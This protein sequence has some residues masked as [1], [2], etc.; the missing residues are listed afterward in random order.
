MLLLRT[1]KGE[2]LA[3]LDRERT[4]IGRD[5]ANDVVLE[6]ASVSGFHALVLNDR[7][8]VSVVDLGSTNGTAVDGKRLRERTELKAW[9]RLQLGGVKLVVADTEVR[10]PTRVQ[11]VVPAAGRESPGATSAK[12]T[13]VRPAAG[14]ATRVVSPV[15]PAG[16]IHFTSPR[17]EPAATR[18][19]VSRPPG[20][21]PAVVEDS[22]RQAETDTSYALF[23]GYPRGL[24]WLLFS[25]QGRIRRSLVWKVLGIGLLVTGIAQLATVFALSRAGFDPFSYAISSSFYGLLTIWPWTAIFAKRIHDSGRRAL[26]WCTLLVLGYVLGI[27]GNWLMANRITQDELVIFGG[28]SL[29]V[30]VPAIYALYLIWF[31]RGD[32]G[33][34]EFGDQNPRRR[35][36]FHA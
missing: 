15:Q 5:P 14:E 34:N 31:K 26:P 22:D 32:E 33:D 21:S 30:V 19:S 4:A 25:F 36:V 35:I 8:A 1:E 24:T 18:V 6:D 13:R 20:A 3:E 10:E 23:G 17:D 27:A 16:D 9:C 29:L 11:P 2:S 28:L 7:G 12:P